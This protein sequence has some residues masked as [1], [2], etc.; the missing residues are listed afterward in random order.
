MQLTVHNNTYEM[1]FF[2]SS[3]YLPWYNIVTNLQFND[4]L[5]MLPNYL[6]LQLELGQGLNTINLS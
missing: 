2:I 5:P 1:T 3:S 6:V 4:H